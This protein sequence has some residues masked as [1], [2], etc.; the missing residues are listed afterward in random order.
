MA[1]NNNG[2]KKNLNTAPQAKVD[3][4][5]QVVRGL[6]EI[7]DLG[8]IDTVEPFE[9][10]PAPPEAK[11]TL[12]V[13]QSTVG[14]MV[15]EEMAEL[16]RI[17]NE[18][19]AETISHIYGGT[20]LL[21]PNSVI[22]SK[23]NETNM[24]QQEQAIQP[25]GHFLNSNG[26]TAAIK[27]FDEALLD[28]LENA[29]TNYGSLSPYGASMCYDRFKTDITTG[30]IDG[31]VNAYVPRYMSNIAFIE[32]AEKIS[33]NN[34]HRTAIISGIEAITPKNTIAF[35]SEVISTNSV[36]CAWDVV[37]A[38][39]QANAVLEASNKY[40]YSTDPGGF[41]QL[42]LS[43][44]ILKTRVRTCVTEQKHTLFP[45]INYDTY[46]R[47]ILKQM[48]S[49][50]NANSLM[51]K[52]IAAAESLLDEVQILVEDNEI[53]N[54]TIIASI[55]A[56]QDDISIAISLLANAIRFM[57]TGSS[58]FS[59]A[60]GS[61][62]RDQWLANPDANIQMCVTVDENYAVTVDLNLYI[63]EELK[64][65]IAEQEVLFDEALMAHLPGDVSLNASVM[66]SLKK[67]MMGAYIAGRQSAASSIQKHSI[68]SEPAF[69]H[70]AFGQL[71]D[72]TKRMISGISKP[73][74]TLIN[75]GEANLQLQAGLNE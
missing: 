73:G 28:K 47:V 67:A 10:A 13:E 39:S 18:I 22:I 50:E 41:T 74:Y 27:Y 17:D 68:G 69:G 5:R 30:D 46:K 20:Q 51:T 49:V 62:T 29:L 52:L 33:E 8:K 66:N 42:D 70:P 16:V 45:K 57:T 1:V 43:E 12:S 35:N 65:S 63:R 31:Q 24:T 4:P 9:P 14:V 19:T 55:E 75:K 3:K 40:I 32:L 56:L 61:N 71:S 64:T 44:L 54:A 37:D 7:R 23:E 6:G 25:V 72:A 21:D 38:V 26:H 60:Y 2:I 36:R 58:I 59:N 34:L 53:E 15:S 48:K 11:T